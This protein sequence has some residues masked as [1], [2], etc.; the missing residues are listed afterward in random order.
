[1]DDDMQGWAH[2]EELEHRQ[3][4]ESKQLTEEKENGRITSETTRSTA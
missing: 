1:M 4:E 3:Y 2:Q